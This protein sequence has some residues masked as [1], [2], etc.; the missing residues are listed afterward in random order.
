MPGAVK[1]SPLH[2]DGPALFDVLFESADMIYVLAIHKNQKQVQDSSPRGWHW[3]PPPKVHF[4]TPAGCRARVSS[5]KRLN[6]QGY[7]IY[8]GGNPREGRSTRNVSAFRMCWVDLDNI[9]ADEADM[10]LGEVRATSG[11][12]APAAT[13]WSG[14]GVHYYWLSPCETA[15]EWSEKQRRLIA[16]FAPVADPAIHD[17]PR[18]MRMPG[19]VNHR[20]GRTATASTHPRSIPVDWSVVPLPPKEKGTDGAKGG[21]KDGSKGGTQNSALKAAQAYF[22][23]R[24]GVAE[25]GRNREAYK[26]AAACSVDFAL[27]M[28]DVMVVLREWNE[29]NQPPLPDE[30]LVAIAQRAEKSARGIPGE[31]NRPR[32]PETPRRDMPPGVVPGEPGPEETETAKDIPA[33]ASNVPPVSGTRCDLELLAELLQT[34]ALIMG[35]TTVWHGGLG[36][37][38][39]Y[40][41]L[42][43]MHPEEAKA[44]RKDRGKRMI[45]AK[46]LV[47]RPDGRLE[48]GQI[49]TFR[50]FTAKRDERDCPLIREHL[51][52]LC[53]NDLELIGWLTCWMAYQVQNPGRKLPTSVIMHGAQGTGKSLLWE[54]FGQIFAPYSGKISQNQIE[55]EFNG[56]AAQKLFIL[57]EEVLAHKQKGRLKNLLKEMVTGG[58]ITINQKY[59][60]PYEEPCMMNMVFLSNELMPMLLE[61][62]DRRYCVIRK[63]GPLDPDYYVVLC[64]EIEDNGAGRL[65]NY[66]LDYNLADREWFPHKR[67]PVTTAKQELIGLGKQSYEDFLES[68][69]AGEIDGLPVSAATGEEL[70][71]A[72]SAWC[73]LSGSYK[74]DRQHLLAAAKIMSKIAYHRT[75]RVRIYRPITCES[76]AT[77]A[78]ARGMKAYV[79][80]VDVF[81]T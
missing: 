7:N 62:D 32:P 17:P 61:K 16:L 44:W 66:L 48:E 78:F 46:D 29:K 27:C 28:D 51:A 9:S 69:I 76:L 39:P 26:V 22:S 31:K 1:V 63:D 56:W 77:E 72:Y 15:A 65:L 20:G 41:A 25:G 57:A 68:W 75:S 43:A 13:V 49:N 59:A 42:C 19:F 10:L 34:C 52:Y 5:L 36:E 3:E 71:L 47:F 54:C 33:P 23:H 2:G 67:P 45:V 50:G 74:Y 55:S 38:I 58:T 6:A 64:Q 18:I 35:T 79:E 11:L 37:R 24:P 30:E 80:R 81:A 4:F 70:F 40:D 14:N 8:F 60:V 12:P 73:R 53:S 21:S